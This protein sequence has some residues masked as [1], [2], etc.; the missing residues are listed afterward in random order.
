MEAMIIKTAAKH[1]FHKSRADLSIKKLN[2]PLIAVIPG[3]RKWQMHYQLQ[4]T[5]AG[6]GLEKMPDVHFISKW[7]SLW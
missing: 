2:F 3:V 7:R 1:I 5:V 4:M 6:A